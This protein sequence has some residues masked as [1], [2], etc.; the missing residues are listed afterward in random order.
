MSEEEET[1]DWV[2]YMILTEG[3]RLY[4]GITNNLEQ[5]WQTHRSGKGAKF[6]RSDPPVKIVYRE[7]IANKS[8]A[9]K[10]EAAIK[11]LSA[12]EKRQLISF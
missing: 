12:R 4:T 3:Q 6:F 9:L 11:K 1:Q 2:V 5:R 7:P 10:R 8:E